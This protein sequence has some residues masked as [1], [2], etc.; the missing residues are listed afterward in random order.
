MS[1]GPEGEPTPSRPGRIY[2]LHLVR[3][4]RYSITL[5]VT[6]GSIYDNAGLCPSEFF[7]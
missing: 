2:G 3:F 1:V 6:S 4:V 5:D 7:G